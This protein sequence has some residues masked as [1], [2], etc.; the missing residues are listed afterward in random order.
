MTPKP[1][2]ILKIILL[3]A[4]MVLALPVAMDI[5][6]P[7]LPSIATLFQVSAGKMQLTLA[8]FMF[9]AG[10][11][12]LF[13]GPLSDQRGRRSICFIMTLIF[14]LST[15]LCARAHTANQLIIFR[16]IQAMG[17]CG[18][19]V[20]GFAIVRDL[21]A[22]KKSAQVYSYLNG[23][24]SFSPMF[25]PFIG[26]YLDVYFGWPATFLALLIIAGASLI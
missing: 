26:S 24:I 12:Q 15:V 20:I 5:Y 21:Y 4:P 22:G 16:C 3:L 6:V 23:L 17:A 14:A 19:M 9:T 13:I 10:L 25:A 11:M 7:A 18:M 1:F 8:V 2:S